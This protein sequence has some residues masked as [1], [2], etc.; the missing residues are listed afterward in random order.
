MST[1]AMVVPLLLMVLSFGGYTVLLLAPAPAMA[2]VAVWLSGDVARAKRRSRSG[3]K[4]PGIQHSGNGIG[5]R[6]TA[7]VHSPQA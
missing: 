4:D 6:I 5:R 3:I 1:L 2:A 7:M